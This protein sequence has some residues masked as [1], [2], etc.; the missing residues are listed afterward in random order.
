MSSA[1]KVVTTEPSDSAKSHLPIGRLLIWRE[2]YQLRKL[3]QVG[4]AQGM[5]ETVGKLQR[6]V[7]FSGGKEYRSHSVRGTP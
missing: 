1:S 4:N 2:L 7:D 5:A 6:A 3:G